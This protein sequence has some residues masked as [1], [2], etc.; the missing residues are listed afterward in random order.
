MMDLSIVVGARPNF[1]KISPLVQQLSDINYHI[2]H[3]GQHYDRNMSDI[4]FNELNIPEP[5]LNMNVGIENTTHGEQT[6]EIIKRFEKYC[7]QYNPKVVVVV[8]DV[9]STLACAI[10]VSKIPHIKLAHIEAG[11]RRATI[12]TPEEVNRRVTDVL[13]DILFCADEES[14][15]NLIKENI[16]ANKIYLVGDLMADN[17]LRNIDNLEVEK[18]RV[19]VTMHRPYNVDN[20]DRLISILNELNKI[21][22]LVDVVF[23]VHPRTMKNIKNFGL[24]NMLKNI[25]ASQPLSSKDFLNNILRSKCVITDS[26]GVQIETSV[27]DIPCITINE[28]TVHKSTI[29]RG[30]NILV[31]DINNLYRTVINI[32]SGDIGK[33]RRDD[34]MIWD[35]MASK[36]IDNILRRSILL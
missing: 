13:S 30:T 8:G 28:E 9:N 33:H 26:G 25:N 29:E 12:D 35:G 24:S 2:V 27:L 23:P 4:F 6:A 34:E 20:K 22:E 11:C 18:D 19:L 5:F 15:N 21:S 17:I 1:Q 7:F 14:Y 32:L 36:R 3:T 31:N 10:V 16:S